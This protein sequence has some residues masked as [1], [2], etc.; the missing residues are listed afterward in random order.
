MIINEEAKK[1]LEEAAFITL[2]TVNAD[3]TPHPIIVAKGTIAGD[4]ISFGI[5]KMEQTQKNLSAN[6]HAWLVGGAVIGETPKGCR[7]TGTAAAKDK[8]LVFTATK[9]DAL[10]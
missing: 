5:Y 7:L 4:T 1:V 10:I 6:K 2:V 8:Q 9:A 3:G